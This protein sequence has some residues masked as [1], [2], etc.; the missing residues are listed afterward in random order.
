MTPNKFK[1]I[2]IHRKLNVVQLLFINSFEILI[3]NL[4][5][6][7]YYTTITGVLYF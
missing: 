7:S 4:Y 6:L 5:C 1:K 3:E 2:T